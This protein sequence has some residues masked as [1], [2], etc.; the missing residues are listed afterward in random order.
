[1]QLS[2][3]KLMPSLQRNV[4]ERFSAGKLD[5]SYGPLSATLKL[6]VAKLC[7]RGGTAV[8]KYYFVVTRT[9]HHGPFQPCPCTNKMCYINA[10]LL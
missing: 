8:A 6:S 10:F 7:V 4:A 3:V 9:G 5:R 1:M 2:V